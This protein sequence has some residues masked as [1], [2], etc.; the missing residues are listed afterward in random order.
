[1]EVRTRRCLL[2]TA[3]AANGAGGTCKGVLAPGPDSFV[4]DVEPWACMAL[5]RLSALMVLAVPAAAVDDKPK[6]R[7]P[8]SCSQT[9]KA[10]LALSDALLAL[11]GNGDAPGTI[12]AFSIAQRLRTRR[13]PRSQMRVMRKLR[14]MAH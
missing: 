10:S 14:P 6:P 11:F 8:A 5:S 12:G 9:F 13:C 4:G 2:S 1:M 3:V 7:L